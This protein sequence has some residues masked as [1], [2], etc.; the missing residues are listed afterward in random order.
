MSCL[1]FVL[2]KAYDHILPFAHVIRPHPG[3]NNMHVKWLQMSKAFMI[4]LAR[5]V[6]YWVFFL[7]ITSKLFVCFICF[8][9]RP[10]AYSSLL[11]FYTMCIYLLWS[12]HVQMY[13]IDL[14]WRQIQVQIISARAWRAILD[15]KHELN[16][17]AA[18][19]PCDSG[20]CPQAGVLGLMGNV[21]GNEA[22]L[23]W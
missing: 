13:V 5:I 14:T 1:G 3:R 17:S 19:L 6:L 21:V 15:M 12:R 22:G 7:C 11:L 10:D 18:W 2:N 16:T 8:Y 23:T 9:L 4:N 20:A